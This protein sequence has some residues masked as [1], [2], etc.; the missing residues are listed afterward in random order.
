MSRLS[1][2]SPS[3]VKAMFSSE[4]DEALIMLL[5]IYDPTQTEEYAVRLAD[6]FTGRLESLTTDQEIVYGVTSRTKEFAFLP[7]QI[8]LPNEQDT[9]VGQCSIVLNYASPDAITLIRSHLTGPTKVLLELVLSGSPDTVEASFPGFYITSA[10][11]NAEAITLELSM[12]SL[13]KEPFPSYNF[14]PGYFPGLF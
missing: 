4:T 8:T 7:M 13:S 5:T 3:A 2:L 1:T 11:Y 6:N 10:T 12:I 14:T 9:G